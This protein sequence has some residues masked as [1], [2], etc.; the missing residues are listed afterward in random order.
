MPAIHPSPH[1]RSV[2]RAA[3][4]TIPAV[5]VASA[6]PAY[7]GSGAAEVDLWSSISLPRE[8]DNGMTFDGD[9][10]YAGIPSP[11]H[12]FDTVFGNDGPDAL[13]A[14]GVFTIGLALGA[15]WD[16]FTV[17]SIGVS[18]TEEA[19]TF[20]PLLR[21][22]ST[23]ADLE[24]HNFTLTQELR[25]GESFPV[26]FT[27]TLLPTPQADETWRGTP[28]VY[29]TIRHETRFSVGTSGATDTGGRINIGLSPAFIINQPT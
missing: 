9:P 3:A 29:P 10:I 12:T 17:T 1:R 16:A 25:A 20:E 15:F 6:A 26:T 18:H 14:G 8:P 5:T 13:P 2:L 21:T 7:A 23:D 11:V 22:T 28:D 27:A 4:W 19:T 24:L